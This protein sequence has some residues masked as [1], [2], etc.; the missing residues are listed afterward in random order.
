M[1]TGTEMPH[2]WTKGVMCTGTEARVASAPQQRE[3]RQAQQAHQQGL[4]GIRH[5]WDWLG[6]ASHDDVAM[7]VSVKYL[8]EG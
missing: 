4:L 8:V 6:V 7:V 3:A 5:A 2:T 1:C